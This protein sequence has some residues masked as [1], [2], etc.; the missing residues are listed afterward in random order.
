MSKKQK[1]IL[2][3]SAGFAV[4]LMAVYFVVCNIASKHALEIFRREVEKQK[5][6]EGIVSVEDIQANLFGE[7]SFVKLQ[8]VNPE[9]TVVA[10]IPEG[11]FKVKP[12]DIILKK[13]RTTT[14]EELSLT[15]AT[16]NIAFEDDM[17]IKYVN[18]DI[19][20][21]PEQKAFLT[22]IAYA[23]NKPDL[24]TTKIIGTKEFKG[25]LE[26]INT[27]ISATYKTRRF[28][29]SD[30]NAKLNLDTKKSLDFLFTTGEFGGT[31]VGEGIGITGS[32]NLTKETP[33]CD[34]GLVIKGVNP[35]SLGAGVNINE[36]VDANA[37]ITGPISAPIIT[38]TLALPTLKIPGLFFKEVTGDFIYE[39]GIIAA[40]NIKANVYGGNVEGK[41]DF[42]IDNKHYNLDILGHELKASEAL[43]KGGLR[44]KVELDLKIR[45]EGRPDNTLTYGTFIS[46]KGDY[47][48]IIQFDSIQGEFSNLNKNLQFT[49]VVIEAKI[50]RI[51]T[52]GF[53]INNGKLHLGKVYLDDE[54]IKRREIYR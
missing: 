3:I 49:N 28:I 19:Y 8:W 32:I 42:N 41:G 27:N 16:V 52:D 50:G 29:I 5:V 6:L 9:G 12:L 31:L 14:I 44:C 4:I 43:E 7:V 24:S 17:T 23:V 53:S 54:A 36:L 2:G 45:S 10:N 38:G 39:A 1:L 34:L 37:M 11:N 26:L 15:N 13:I 51:Y 40:T 18:R 47:L 48:K 35:Q 25:K 46:G 20:A 22:N 30:V 21:K 33:E